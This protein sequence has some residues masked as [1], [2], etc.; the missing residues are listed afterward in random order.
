MGTSR[1]KTPFRFQA[2]VLLP[3]IAVMA[4]SVIATVWVVNLR[5]VHQLETEGTHRLE[6]AEAVFKNSQEIRANHLLLRYRNVPNEP[7]F[8]A[9]SQLA[10]PATMRFSLTRMLDELNVDALV[11]T[12]EAGKRLASATR[13]STLNT[14]QLSSDNLSV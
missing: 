12:T 3:V 11:F 5:I 8:R 13:D 4:T 2:K 7:G 10:D 9:L 14:A 6:T 1:R